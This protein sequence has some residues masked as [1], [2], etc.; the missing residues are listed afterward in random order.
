MKVFDFTNGKRGEL[1]GEVARPNYMEG[2]LVRKGNKVF[3]IE[4][5]KKRVGNGQWT[6]HTGAG[7]GFVGHPGHSTLRPEDFGVS[8]ICFSVGQWGEDWQWTVIGTDDW[9]RKA[10]KCGILSYSVERIIDENEEQAAEA[11]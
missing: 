6:W 7:R 5:A 1:L 9:N 10:V 2:C 11:A 3:R 4:M 8:A